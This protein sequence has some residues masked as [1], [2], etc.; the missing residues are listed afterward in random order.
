MKPLK[1]LC[2]CVFLFNAFFIFGGAV[3]GQTLEEGFRQP[4]QEAHP[5][6]WWHWV[7][8]NVSKEGITLDLEAMKR[9]GIA[10]AQIFNVNQGPQGPVKTFSAEWHQLV[11]HAVR[12]SARLGM[13]LG[14]ENC[15]G[16]SESGGPWVKP[17]EAMQFVFTTEAMV[18]GGQKI[19]ITLSPG[20]RMAWG[21]IATWAFPAVAGDDVALTGRNEALSASAGAGGLEKICDGK[22]ETFAVIPKA[23]GAQF[24]QVAFSEPRSFGSFRLMLDHRKWDT[25]GDVA[26]SDDGVEFRKIGRITMSVFCQGDTHVYL[27]SFAPA[28]ARYWRL[29]FDPDSEHA[30]VHVCELTFAGARMPMW[31]RKAAYWADVTSNDRPSW[32]IPGGMVID[33]K[34]LVNLSDKIKPDGTLE[35]DAPAGNWTVV[36]FGYA[37][38]GQQNSPATEEATGWECDKLSRAAVANHFNNGLMGMVLKDAGPQAGKALKTMLADSWEAGC[39]NWTPAMREEFQKRCGYDLL[40][41]LPTLSGRIVG[42]LEQSER[43]LWDFRR[44]IADLTADNHYG[45]L[46]DLAHQH[47]LQF[48]AEA[49]GIFMPAVADELQ[50]KGRV[51]IPMGEFWIPDSPDKGI[52]DCKE[53]SSAAHIN[54]LRW[55]AAEAYTAFP[56][57]SSWKNDPFSLKALGDRSFCL[58]INR[59]VFHRYAHQPF[60]NR[61][62]GITMGPWGINFERTQTWWEQGRAW[63]DYLSRCQWMLSQGAF[64]AD[65][66][67]FYGEGAPNTLPLRAKLGI[68]EGYDYDGCDAETLLKMEVRDGR[69][70]LPGGMSYRLLVLPPTDR[71]TPAVLAKIR[72]LARAGA[73]IVGNRVSQSPSLRNYP[74]ADGILKN[75]ADELWGMGA[76]TPGM[77]AVGKGRILFG[78]ALDQCLPQLG[79]APDFTAKPA[80][81][82][83]LYIHRALPKGDVYFVSNQEYRGVDAACRFRVAGRVPEFWHPDTGV[84]EAAPVYTQSGNCIEVP[85]HLDAAGSVFVVFRKDQGRE[86]HLVSI[87][88]AGVADAPEGS[89]ALLGTGFDLSPSDGWTTVLTPW[90]EGTYT[91]TFASGRQWRHEVSAT[92][93]NRLPGPWSLRFPP[94]WGAPGQ[95]TLEQ[96][97]SWADHPEEGVKHFSGTAVYT[98]D[99]EVNAVQLGAGKALRLNLGVVKNLAEVKVNGRDLGVLWKPPFIVDIS[100]IAKPGRNTLEVKVTNLWPNRMI[101]DQSIAPEK[102]YTWST[103]SP[104]QADTP[105]LESGLIGPVILQSAQMLR[106]NP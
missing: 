69:L 14:F 92:P 104:F 9:V 70:V 63:M 17:E 40:P 102:R 8:G 41:W 10:E 67:Y 56:S 98:K 65:V 54:G 86:D 21:D 47:G 38:K 12:E 13:Q 100:G 18:H 2:R 4:S 79:L 99:F 43:F 42:S 55:A 71:M 66:C 20:N 22:E 89:P 26:I 48:Y 103:V 16:W 5:R 84:I 87:R 59:I 91:A 24:L 73:S 11:G 72:D 80:T 25:G 97:I 23:E 75:L 85:M 44:V 39:Q 6:T 90:V 7:S 36:R 94:G 88:R 3:R 64:V 30:E 50:C 35:W 83:L 19:K 62:P 78:K 60:A 106:V 49:P 15:P 96:L 82:K 95:V 93:E 53:A 29:E 27:S 34:T 1:L 32:A 105:L 76:E 31:D 28:K 61:F 58:G 74:Q 45:E 33:P 37:S 101:G 57:L 52:A 51:D 68:P 46:R 77:R 81:A